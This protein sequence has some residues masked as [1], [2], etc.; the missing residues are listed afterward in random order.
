[1]ILCSFVST[2]NPRYKILTAAVN[3]VSSAAA[4]TPASLLLLL[5]LPLLIIASSTWRL[6]SSAGSALST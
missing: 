2:Y 6:T 4:T 1:V 5:L 3:R